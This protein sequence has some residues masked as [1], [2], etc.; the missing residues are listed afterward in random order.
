VTPTATVSGTAVA[1]GAPTATT[2]IR[3]SIPARPEVCDGRDNNCNSRADELEL[4]ELPVDLPECRTQGVCAGSANRCRDGAWS[5]DYPATYEGPENGPDEH[6]C[7]LLDND[8]DGQV[9]ESF[10]LMSDPENC[11]LCGR[12]CAFA[13]AA[14][15]C[16]DAQCERGVCDA[17]WNDVDGNTGNGCEYL[18]VPSFGGVEVCDGLDNDCNGRIDE[19]FEG[20]EVCDGEDNDCDGQAD[21]DWDLQTSAEHCGRCG[22]AVRRGPRARVLRG[23]RVCPGCLRGRLERRRRQPRQRLRVRLLRL[24]RR[25]RSL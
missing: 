6:T 17:G 11:G 23:R 24:E 22:R 9:D 18:C 20:G 13:N 12:I 10:E 7:D 14:A 1:A 4:I 21:E 25:R 19:G 2:A 15:Q 5:C 3:R 8:C 16:F